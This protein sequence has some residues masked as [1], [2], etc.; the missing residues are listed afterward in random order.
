MAAI[1]EINKEEMVK[2]E[3][4]VLDVKAGFISDLQGVELYYS[5]FTPKGYRRRDSDGIFLRG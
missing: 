2:T 1:Y 4:V 5:L 3:K